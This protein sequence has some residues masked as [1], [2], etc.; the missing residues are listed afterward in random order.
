[1]N[2][3]P[4]PPD[5]HLIP[6]RASQLVSEV[7]PARD[8]R[9]APGQQQ[10]VSRQR[11]PQVVD[12]VEREALLKRYADTLQQSTSGQHQGREGRRAV[13][14]YASVSQQDKRELLTDLLGVNE[15]A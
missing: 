3:L 8:A 12:D 6:G 15:Y 9:Q 1:M 13:D 11:S 5:P 10:E 4:V 7:L 14:A 2:L